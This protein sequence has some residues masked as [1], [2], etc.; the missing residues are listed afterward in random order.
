VHFPASSPYVTG[1]GGT[2]FNDI[3]GNYWASNDS[4][5]GAS[6]LSYIPEN[7]WNDGF[8]QAA[9]GGASSLITIKPIWQTGP[10][11]PGDGVRD[12]PDLAFSASPNHDGYLICSVGSCTNGFEDSAGNLDVVGGTSAT[13]PAFAGVLALVIQSNGAGTRLGNINPNLY[14]LA[15]ISSNAFHDV[16][17]GNNDQAC[18]TGTPDCPAGGGQIGY[19]AGAGYDQASGLGSIDAYNFA[20]QWYGDIELTATPATVTVQPGSSATATV[21]V[22]PVN[23][24]SGEVSFSC[25]VSTSLY[26]VTCSVPSTTVNT[27]G[28]TTVT[29]S[30]NS[31]SRTFPLFKKFRGMPLMEVCLAVLALALISFLPSRTLKQRFIYGGFSAF[32]VA[33]SVGAVSCG[34][35]GSTP[36]TINSS[37][38]AA[39][40]R[41]TCTFAGSPFLDA[42][43]TG[44]TCSTSGGTAP[45]TYSISAG[46]LPAGLTINS[47]TGAITGTATAAGTSAFTIKVTDSGSPAQT[48]TQEESGLVVSAAALTISCQNLAVGTVGVAYNQSCAVTG[49]TPPLTY[50]LSIGNLPAGLSLNSS[51]GAIT[52]IP[53]EVQTFIIG[54]I[55]VADS[56][57]PQQ[58]NASNTLMSINPPGVLAGLGFT[59]VGLLGGTVGFPVNG[60]CSPYNGTP[61]YTYSLSGTLPPGLVFNA[62]GVSGTPTTAGTN[63]FNITIVDS[64][65]PALTGQANI[66]FTVSPH[67]GETGTVTVTATSGGIVNST[68]IAVNV[69]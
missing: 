38:T 25:S 29:I 14:S 32:L 67:G 47:S 43:Y 16:I 33:M 62:G 39:P 58:T 60:Y 40:L 36:T 55:N 28:S 5:G 18:S 19:S 46:A 35:G 56:G 37:P 9:G 10:G 64:S 8:Q 12:V 23:Q 7:V 52:G 4:V 30:A 41:L 24:F 2:T 45:F 3:G 6:A 34:G 69:Q 11:V 21:S 63:L 51:T 54:E 53:T 1:V 17:S 44:G 61:P 68:T 49:G 42:A 48:A 57:T 66:N 31:S 27:S 50:S 20:Q 59:C 26:G 22:S 65:S 15:Q 13:A